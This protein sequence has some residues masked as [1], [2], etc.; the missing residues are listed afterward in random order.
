MLIICTAIFAWILR[1]KCG[2]EWTGAPC[3][4]VLALFC[5]AGLLA[6]LI[7]RLTEK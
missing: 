1:A 2:L 7:V 3:G 6:L 5:D 4:Y